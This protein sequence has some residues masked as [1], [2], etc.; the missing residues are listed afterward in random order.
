MTRTATLLAILFC[1]FSLLTRSLLAQAPRFGNPTHDTTQFPFY[2]DMMQDRSINFYQTQR[3]FELY[4][5][6]RTNFKSNGYK[7]FKRWEWMAMQMI[8]NNGNFPNESQQYRELLELIDAQQHGLQTW[9]AD[10]NLQGDWKELGPI[11]LPQNNTSQING[12]GRLNAMVVHP[13]DT[14]ILYAGSCSGG[15]WSSYDGGKTWSVYKDSLP[16]LG[17]SSIAVHPTHPDTLY[18]GSGDRD[19]NDAPGFGVY[20]S[21]DGGQSWIRHAQGMGNTIVGKLEMDPHN[22]NTLLAATHNGIYKS[23]NAALN[24]TRVLSGGQFK[25]LAYMPNQ[26]NVVYATRNGLFFRS[27]NGGNNWTQITNGLPASG[28]S[29]G[30][31]AVSPLDSLLVY[32]WTANGSVHQGFYMSNDGGV[33]FKTMSTTPNL[34]DYATNGSGNNGQAWFNKA[35][36]VDPTDAGVVYCGGVNIFRSNDS[37]KT[38]QIAGY[39]VNAIHAD[40]HDL[41]TCYQTQRV[42]AAND[43][44]LYFSKNRGQSWTPIKSGLAISQIYNIGTS[45]TQ[46]NILIAGFQDNGTANF[47]ANQW[48][49]TRGGDG[50]GCAVDQQD[51]RYS[52]GELY[53]GRIFR[54]F[55]NRTV[56]TIAGENIN[57]INESGAWNTPFVL[58]EDNNQT[59]YVGYK[60]I[61]RSNNIRSNN[62]TWER[63]SNNLGGVNNNNFHKLENCIANPNILYAARA[64]GSFYISQNINDASPTWANVNKPTS[65]LVRAIETDPQ[66]ENIVYI[67]IGNQVYKSLNKGAAWTTLNHSLPANVNALLLDTSSA[68]KGIYAGTFGTGIWYTDSTMNDWKFFSR[69]IPYTSRITDLQ[70]YYDTATDCNCN[71]IYASTYNRGLW[72]SSVYQD[73]SLKPIAKLEPYPGKLGCNDPII[74]F[75]SNSCNVPTRFTWDFQSQH[76]EFMNGTDSLSS[77][78]SVRFLNP[79]TYSFYFIAENCEGS[80]T[81]RGSVTILDTTQ[82]YCTPGTQNIGNFGIGIYGVQLNN[83][84]ISSGPI[85]QE[86]PYSD[87]TCEEVIILK[88]DT[89]YVIEITTGTTYDEQVSVHIDYNNDGN[90]DAVQELAMHSSRARTQHIDTLRIPG[91]A[92]TG[93]PLRMRVRTDYLSVTTQA[94]DDL[95]YGQTLDLI[96]YIEND[97]FYP[98]FSFSASELCM[99]DTVTFFDQTLIEGGDY[100]WDFGSDAQPQQAFS[101]GPHKVVYQTPGPKSISLRVGI[102]THTQDSILVMHDYPQISVVNK[103]VGYALCENTALQFTVEDSA[104]TNPQ[105]SWK[106]NH[107]QLTETSATLLIPNATPQESGFYQVLASHNGCKDSLLLDSVSVFHK[108]HSFFTWQQD[109]M[110]CLKSNVFTMLN[111]SSINQGTLWYEWQSGDGNSYSLFEPDITYNQS[112]T[113]AL[114]LIS[115]SEQGCTDTFIRALQVYPSPTAQGSTQSQSFCVG[116]HKVWLSNSSPNIPP[117]TEFTWLMGNGSELEEF[118]TS[119]QYTETGTYI[120]QLV[121]NTLQGCND[122]FVLDT[123][124]VHP[125]PQYELSSPDTLCTHEP[126]ILR[127]IPQESGL[128]YTWVG[129]GNLLTGTSQFMVES[130]TQTTIQVAVMIQNRFQCRDT[131]QFKLHISGR[132][133]LNL[134]TDTSICPD[135]AFEL[136]ITSGNTQDFHLWSNGS[137]QPFIDVSEPQTY[138]VIVTNISGCSSEDSVRISEISVPPL[139]LGDDRWVAPQSIIAEELNAGVG[140]ISYAWNTGQNTQKI[141]ARDTGWYSVEAVSTVGC[142]LNRSIRVQYFDATAS[143]NQVSTPAFRVYPNPAK[144]HVFL[145]GPKQGTLTVVNNQGSRVYQ[146]KLDPDQTQVDVSNWATGLYIFTITSDTNQVHYKVIISR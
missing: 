75:K 114:T 91:H 136:R 137:T 135:Q 20:K 99:G 54:V 6:N 96:V 23:T 82:S 105:W 7:P 13:Q 133:E 51:N 12:M 112:G 42:Y 28:V 85:T 5:E 87:R 92:L 108:P 129:N 145:E 11:F 93:I 67:S 97:S 36:T 55:N 45:R 27:Q 61:W 29:R 34:H 62:P 49:T 71:V 140:F 46:K 127:A 144:D 77:N 128:E 81:V 43:G 16:T 15:F 116:A 102:E 143:Q 38:W 52:Y 146:G 68:K 122:T 21:A 118:E 89:G 50:M 142:V 69:G 88:K 3:A 14:Q 107:Q 30:V 63:I 134:P 78:P 17:V 130:D 53:Y 138:S 25:D 141:I 37:G 98:D 60:N 59:M 19:A 4:W 18:F 56:A 115:H 83:L 104:H 39:W 65:G 35:I 139:E 66:S 57:G 109:S 74:H 32:F 1:T 10:C 2:A 121:A 76:I 22:P 33:S 64:N 106:H 124:W 47:N 95:R 103:P 100:T 72:Y 44:G 113:F 131:Q 31:I 80:D 73:S 110:Q 86:G 48:F 94:C 40:Q 58:K 126:I 101:A 90:F 8:D 24:W 123:I 125:Q 117:N 79:G 70:M 41:Y 119:Y 132:P 84:N 120:P 111:R 9:G 26:S